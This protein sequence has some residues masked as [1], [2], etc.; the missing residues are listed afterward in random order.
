MWYREDERGENKE[1][2]LR[3]KVALKYR[4]SLFLEQPFLERVHEHNVKHT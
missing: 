1:P 4:H 3:L 2:Q